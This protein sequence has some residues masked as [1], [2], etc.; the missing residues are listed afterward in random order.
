MQRLFCIAMMSIVLCSCIARHDSRS[1]DISPVCWEDAVNIDYVNS[2]TVGVRDVAVAI[3]FDSSAPDSV[4]LAIKTT[5][6][7]GYYT[8]D[9]LCAFLRNSQRRG[10]YS[11]CN[12]TYRAEAVLS[13]SG[14][15]QININ[16]LV[17]VKGIWGMA[18]N[19][20]DNKWAKEKR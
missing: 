12:V 9:T 8:A 16:P 17:P 18:I 5:D 11:E 13:H 14:I 20:S 15:Y 6:P 19:F 2:D 10:G 7:R 4:V 1:V 3:R